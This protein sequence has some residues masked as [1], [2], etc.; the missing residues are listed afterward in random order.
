MLRKVVV[1]FMAPTRQETVEQLERVL[2]SRV[3]HGSESL[4][5]FLKFVVLN[6]LDNGSSGLKEYTIATEV[7]GRSPTYDPRSDSVVRVQAGRL[8]SKLQE[9]YTSEGRDDRV[10]IDLPKGHYAPVLSYAKPKVESHPE[11]APDR[12]IEASPVVKGRRRFN[13]MTISVAGLAVISL[14]MAALTLSYR[15][16]NERL[17][18]QLATAQQAQG[19]AEASAMWQPLMKSPDPLL[20]AFSNTLFEGTAETGM[21]L[22]N[23]IDTPLK[24]VGEPG[25]E[26]AEPGNAK[27][28]LTEHYTGTGEV[29][30]MYLISSLLSKANRPFRVKRSLL[31]TWDDMTAANIVFLGSPA[32]NFL[33]RDLPQHQDFTFGVIREG[34]DKPTFGIINTKPGP[35]EQAFY[36]A[37]QEGPSRSQISEDYALVSM[38]KGLD[39]RHRILILAGI[40]TFGTQAAA[41]YAVEPQYADSLASHLTQ[42]TAGS[43]QLPTYYQVLVKVKVNGGVPVQLTYVTHHVL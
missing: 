13:S 41:E 19:D 26:R 16:E 3:L 15:S 10:L 2:G 18:G 5:A 40:T 37:S 25:L 32:E 22:L 30:G 12:L 21:K 36:F 23:P 4:R 29:M 11:P 33:L 27:T 38:L 31:L 42:T 6:S 8:R 17:K 20:V 43:H 7:F 1:V 39:D 24:N 35:G 9:Y 14:A 28:V 34:V